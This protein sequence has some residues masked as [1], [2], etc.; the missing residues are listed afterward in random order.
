[1]VV[2]APTNASPPGSS[3]ASGD[4]VYSRRLA[5]LQDEVARAALTG[6]T[7]VWSPPPQEA[8][9]KLGAPQ[10]PT[11]HQSPEVNACCHRRTGAESMLAAAAWAKLDRQAH[12]RHSVAHLPPVA[13]AGLHLSATW[14]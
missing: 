7:L 4:A 11:P 2:R 13:A 14:R 6:Q 8:P 12:R 5:Q 1:M 9:P 10:F 3:G